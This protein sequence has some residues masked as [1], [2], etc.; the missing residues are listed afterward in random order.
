MKACPFCKGRATKLLSISTG[1]LTCQQ[2]G[3]SYELPG[4]KDAVASAVEQANA[5]MERRFLYGE[6]RLNPTG[7]LGSSP[8]SDAGA[9][10]LLRAAFD[11]DEPE[12]AGAVARSASSKQKL[13][14]RVRQKKEKG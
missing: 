12:A 6:G 14:I 13:S 11:L 9:K 4:L 7:L 10:R 3:R 1:L 2:C 5:E 8:L